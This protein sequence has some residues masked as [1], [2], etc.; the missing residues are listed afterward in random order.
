MERSKVG[1]IAAMVSAALLVVVVLFTAGIALTSDGN[2]DNDGWGLYVLW[3]A[4]IAVAVIAAA[5]AVHGAL[6]ATGGFGGAMAKVAMGLAVLAVPATVFAWLWFGWG[7]LL[8]VSFLLLAL[9]LR[10]MGLGITGHKSL[11]DWAMPVAF[12]IG[13]AVMFGLY[14]TVVEETDDIDWGY[15]TGF[16]ISLLVAAATLFKLGQWLRADVPILQEAQSA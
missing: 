5:V 11:W 7:G 10:A 3:I 8:A 1:G 16:A 6:K 13:P 15:A 12:L 14:A 2:S 9:H 4:M